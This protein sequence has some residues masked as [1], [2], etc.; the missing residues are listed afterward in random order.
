MQSN[1]APSPQSSIAHPSI[2]ATS[3]EVMFQRM[4]EEANDVIATWELDGCLTYISPSF[5]TT[6]GHA[7][8]DWVGQSFGPLV[9][10]DDLLTCLT[11]N[12]EVAQ[13][14]EKRSNIE[15]RHRHQQ[16]HWVW[17]AVSI[18]PI[19]D[20]TGQ[21][22]G[23]Q[24]ILRDV[25]ELKQKEAE[26]EHS[27]QLLQQIIDVLPIS[28]A[29]KDRNSVYQGI[30]EHFLSACGFDSTQM[31]VGRTDYDM[32]WTK[33]EADWYRLCDQRVMAS[34]K[35]EFN[36]LETQQRANGEQ[37]FLNTNKVPLR[38]IDG[39]V[40]GVL[41]TVEDITER[42]LSA[43]ALEDYADRQ[44]LLNKLSSQIRQSLDL[45]TV[46]A[47]TIE[48]IRELLEIDACAFAWYEYQ[49]DMPVWNMIQ[50]ARL[51]SL[52]T[53][54]GCY[55]AHIVG[56]SEATLLNQE[57][58]QINDVSQC[59]KHTH[60]DFLHQ[61]KSQSE[62]LLPIRTQGDRLGVIICEHY[63]QVRPWSNDE[64][65]LLKAVSNQLAIAIDQANLYAESHRNS[66]ELQ[67]ALKELQQTQSKMLQNE[68]MSSLGQ[69][70]AGI[71][72]EINNPV[73]F[74]HG[75]INYARDYSRDLLDLVELYQ[76][77]Y[78]QPTPTIAEKLEEIDLPFL[79]NDLQNVLS[80]M[81][82]GSERIREIVKSLR[83]F[84][85]LDE[86][87]I[88]PVNIHDGLDSTLMILK[89]RLSLKSKAREIS[90]VKHYAALPKVDCFAGQLNQVF[91]NIIA[92]AIDALEE[93]CDTAPTDYHPCI[94]ITTVEQGDQVEIHFADN[95]PGI[96]EAVQAQIFD[97][98]F[99]TKDVG[100]GTGMGMAISYQIITEKHRGQLIC[101]SQPGQGTE[102]VISIPIRQA[103]T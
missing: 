72:H 57:V 58:L 22:V 56:V 71:A 45:E 23:L 36:I 25:S 18:S 61:L 87:E 34:G 26:L 84:S 29:W 2:A 44:M 70:V 42:H 30:N 49:D 68:K 10:P 7:P 46:I 5:Q 41:A 59:E 85:R 102:F 77:A 3:R 63:Q 88:K 62:L 75:N 50:E 60:S 17:V 100:K 53:A 94:T 15:F 67:V 48:S 89:N 93:T 69:L 9:H 91:L 101:R 19:K 52:P 27:R 82:M 78:P 13:T 98:F 21:V 1:S 80:S 33:D 96:P 8:A 76:A 37:V 4:V 32:P 43:L 11:A 73:N 74:I 38:D 65:E 92:N 40:T 31:A 12:Q 90:V 20:A 55:P 103:I 54:I 14:G 51:P 97:P 6:L 83:L 79:Q 35:A 28:I 95:G 16:G 39:N 66:Q 86:A 24:G 47:T 99:T 81:K 64:V